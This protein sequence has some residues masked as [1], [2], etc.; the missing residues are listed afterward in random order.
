MSIFI[1]Y[2][3]SLLKLPSMHIKTTPLPFTPFLSSFST[4][5]YLKSNYAINS[6]IAPPNEPRILPS[7]LQKLLP[8]PPPSPEESYL[9]LH[10]VHHQKVE[11][12]HTQNESSIHVC[13][14]GKLAYLSICLSS[15]N[16]NIVRVLRTSDMKFE[17][18]VVM[19][20]S[21]L[22]LLVCIGDSFSWLLWGDAMAHERIVCLPCA[23]SE[24]VLA[25]ILSCSLL[26]SHKKI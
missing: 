14:H 22:Q 3:S 9:E 23:I 7:P 8:F 26:F 16:T 5:L 19:A 15:S 12:A 1:K 6:S 2:P 17:G 25:P 11:V 24:C 18:C 10:R 13:L 20:V 21:A 4:T